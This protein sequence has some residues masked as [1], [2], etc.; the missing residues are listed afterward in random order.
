VSQLPN[1][2]AARFCHQVAVC[3]ISFATFIRW[4]IT[5]SPV[6]QQPLEPNK[7][8]TDILGIAENF[9]VFLTIFA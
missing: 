4:E 8:N 6:T 9:G 7:N 1:K 3:Q 2:S 5:K